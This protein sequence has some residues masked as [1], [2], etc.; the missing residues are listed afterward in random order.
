MC[1]VTTAAVALNT[2]HSQN[3]SG[4]TDK[5]FFF[6]YFVQFLL[7]SRYFW[8]GYGGGGGGG[9]LWKQDETILET[10]G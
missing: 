6:I 8:K 4:P 10:W 1:M 5:K 7:L 9:D 2:A 3:Y